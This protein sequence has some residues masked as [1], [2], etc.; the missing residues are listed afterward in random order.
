M[1]TTATNITVVLILLMFLY[2]GYSAGIIKSFFAAA[3][4]FFSLLLAENYPNQ[5]GI[6]YYFVFV[7]TA[8]IIFI[9]GIIILKIVKFLYL[10]L[11]DKAAGACLGLFL[12]FIVAVN[13]VIP[14]ADKLAGMVSDIGVKTEY[15]SNI[16]SKIFPMFGSYIPKC[17]HGIN[18]KNYSKD[19]K[20]GMDNI[21]RFGG[22]SEEL[23]D[24]IKNI[25]KDISKEKIKI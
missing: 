3:A 16:S 13:F 8:V 6:N 14:T 11:F 24:R 5:E 21:K 20:D 17:L 4:G 25:S 22:V 1:L 10:S 2:I 9:A 18:L 23:N 15:V 7:A 19:I 12:G